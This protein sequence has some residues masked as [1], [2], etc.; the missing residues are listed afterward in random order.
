MSAS[1]SNTEDK[2]SKVIRMCYHHLGK[3]IKSSNTSNTVVSVLCN[4]LNPFSLLS[5]SLSSV[6]Y[7]SSWWHAVF[8]S[9]L[10]NSGS[11]GIGQ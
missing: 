1:I 10:A 2:S 6:K 3:S 9:N 4:I 11:W 8:S 7:S 5:S